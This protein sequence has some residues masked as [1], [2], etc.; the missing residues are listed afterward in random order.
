MPDNTDTYTSIR[1]WRRTAKKLKL[2]AAIRD[3][4]M[5]TAIDALVTEDLKRRGV[6]PNGDANKPVNEHA[7]K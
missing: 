7:H 6:I 5:I 4:S 2:L 3:Q 1:V